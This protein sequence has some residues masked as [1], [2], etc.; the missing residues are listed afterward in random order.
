MRTA[1]FLYFLEVLTTVLLFFFQT[2]EDFTT[3]VIQV[4]S[5]LCENIFN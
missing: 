3:E 4:Q 2:L 1:Q 5:F